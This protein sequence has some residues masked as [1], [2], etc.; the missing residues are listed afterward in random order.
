MVLK[1]VQPHEPYSVWTPRNVNPRRISREHRKRIGDVKQFGERFE[2]VPLR[3]FLSGVHHCSSLQSVTGV[4]RQFS[5]STSRAEQLLAAFA[6]VFRPAAGRIVTNL[7]DTVGHQPVRSDMKVYA[8]PA[9]ALD[10]ETRGHVFRRRQQGLLI[11]AAIYAVG[12]GGAF[13]AELEIGL[14]PVEAAC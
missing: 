10:M 6:V 13:P 8:A 2:A 4:E 3:N 12:V 9:D 11:I 1:W 14:R 7:A 5:A